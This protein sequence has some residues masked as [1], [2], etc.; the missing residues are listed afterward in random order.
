MRKG[1][2][3]SRSANFGNGQ[4]LSMSETGQAGSPESRESGGTLGCEGGS[5]GGKIVAR[6]LFAGS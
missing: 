3:G 1:T 4:W 6:R 2:S 5:A